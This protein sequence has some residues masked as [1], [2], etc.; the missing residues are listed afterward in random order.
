MCDGT[1]FVYDCDFFTRGAMADY[2]DTFDD[3]TI[4]WFS[5]YSNGKYNWFAALSTQ[6]Y[7]HGGYCW[8]GDAACNCGEALDQYFKIAD[9][10]TT[11]EL[12]GGNASDVVTA[13]RNNGSHA[14]DLYDFSQIKTK[15]PSVF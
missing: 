10:Y 12:P 15:C 3:G 1:G 8:M 14:Q 5:Q 11:A 6:D 9:G 13:W 7:S 2:W 4:S